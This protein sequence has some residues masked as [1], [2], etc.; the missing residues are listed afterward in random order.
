[1]INKIEVRERLLK[2]VKRLNTITSIVNSGPVTFTVITR[3][4]CIAAFASGAYLLVWSTLS[5]TSLLFSL[6]YSTIKQKSMMQLSCLL[7]PS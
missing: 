5:E 1:M 3:G 2:K 4:L 7:K 6:K